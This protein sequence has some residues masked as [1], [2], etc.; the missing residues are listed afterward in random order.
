MTMTSGNAAA[1]TGG[2]PRSFDELRGAVLALFDRL[3]ARAAHSSA[4]APEAAQRAAAAQGRLERGQLV[5]AVCGEFKRGKS[6][7][8]TALL[9]E[10]LDRLRLF[11]AD[12]LPATNSVSTVRWGAQERILVTVELA[13][14]TPQTTPIT[15]EQIADY[16]T[17]AGNPGNSRKVVLI[18]IETPNEKLASGLAFADTPGVGGVLTEHTVVTL[19]FL[20]SADALLFVTDIEKP[21]AGSELAFLR[22]AIDAA[23]M[24]DDVGSLVCVMTKIDQGTDYTGLLAENRAKLADLTGLPEDEVVLIPVSSW[25]KLEYLED[26]DPMTLAHSN[27]PEL[28]DALWAA[29]GRRRAKVLL[30]DALRAVRERALAI[31]APIEA[32]A[33]SARDATGKVLDELEREARDREEYLKRLGG[34]SKSWE[35]DLNA[36]LKTASDKLIQLAQNEVERIWSQFNGQYVYDTALLEEPERLADRLG[37]DMSAM[38]GGL[39]RLVRREVTA[40]VERFSV[41]K[42]LTL[43]APEIS[44]LPDLESPDLP[45][46]V[47]GVG[48]GRRGEGVVVARYTAAS[49]GIGGA[50]GGVIGAVLGSVLLPGAGTVGGAVLG[51]QI[52]TAVSTL[53]GGWLGFRSSAKM[54]KTRRE[55]ARRT[56]LIRVFGPAKG[57]QERYVRSL[58]TV[59]FNG[60]RPAAI[61]ELKSRIRQE[62]E[63][64]ANVLRRLATTRKAAEAGQAATEAQFAAE[65]APFDA[66]LA[67]DDDL[68]AEAAKLGS[69]N[70]C[71][72]GSGGQG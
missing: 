36:E 3:D 38:L 61:A 42:G 12:T 37:S 67:D 28:E 41:A 44:E 34:D 69:K 27:F 45:R 39:L 47:S 30:G 70:G 5:T 66:V 6:T 58:L 20:P 48:R 2:C 26:G 33:Q 22:E 50:A 63:T 31:L 1:A 71:A 15:R 8:L 9:D 56:E 18:E 54:V 64:T 17:E 21:L 51:G 53:I 68:A 43:K 13:D 19:A 49:A 14:G 55:D 40:A 16:A 7:L 25:Q 65:R 62:R 52:G 10:P 72:T 59:A 32:A 23:R 46:D 29:L 24:T 35:A 11:P 60:I 57:A 4:E